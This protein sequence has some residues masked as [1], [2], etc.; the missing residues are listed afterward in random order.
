MDNADDDLTAKTMVGKV[1]PDTQ[2][3]YFVQNDPHRKDTPF[4]IHWSKPYDSDIFIELK[5]MLHIYLCKVYHILYRSSCW[6][7]GYIDRYTSLV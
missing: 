1:S 7:M 2:H 5:I 4:T 6:S 3:N